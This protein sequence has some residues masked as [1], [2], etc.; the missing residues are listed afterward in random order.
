MNNMT[1]NKTII[2][3]ISVSDDNYVQHLAVMM[4]SILIN[5]KEEEA[6]N[7]YIMDGGISE[8]SKKKLNQLKEI[9]DFNINYIV[10][11][12]KDYE[13]CPLTLGYVIN[14]YYRFEILAFLPHLS[15][16][17]LLDSDLIVRGSLREFWEY[18]L[19]GKLVGAVENPFSLN[20]PKRLKYSEQNAYFNAGV[21]LMDLD[22]LREFNFESKC[23]E[24]VKKHSNFIWHVDQCVINRVLNENWKRLPYR[25]NF[26]SI[27]PHKNYKPEE[28]SL[29]NTPDEEIKD[30]INDNAL[31]AHFIGSNKPWEFM[32]Q[33]LYMD[34]YWHYLKKTPWK[35]YIPDDLSFKN[36]VK[37]LFLSCKVLNFIRKIL[38][39]KVYHFILDTELQKKQKKQDKKA[40]DK[41]KHSYPDLDIFKIALSKELQNQE[42]LY[43]D[44]LKP[45]DKKSWYKWFMTNTVSEII[46]S[47]K[48]YNDSILE[49]AKLFLKYDGCF[50]II[51]ENEEKVIFQKC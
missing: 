36:A 24:F 23:F 27:V 40:Q 28:Y 3:I 17:L 42:Y 30:A 44:E 47:D 14:T 15:K 45:T 2:E 18:D 10:G 25:F 41:F 16:V 46:I 26:M 11:K 34:E 38:G 8:K 6:F 39:K 12:N 22:K 9:K 21:M 19:E 33:R 43:I 49:N 29:R 7:F 13:F 48:N 32:G 5:S 51:E 20:Y 50:K 37:K 1:Q 31:I 4:V 35:Y